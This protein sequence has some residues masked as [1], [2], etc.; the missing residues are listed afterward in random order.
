MHLIFNMFSF[1]FFGLA[2]ER[3]FEGFFA[4]SGK[5]IYLF[6]YVSALLMSLLPTYLKHRTNH[7]YRSLGASGAVSTV[8]F[9]GVM[10]DPIN[11]IYVFFIPMPGFVFGILYLVLTAYM[12]KKGGDSIN[13]SAHLWGALYGLVFIIAAGYIAGYDLITSFTTSVQQYLGF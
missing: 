11:K 13:H 12:D 7:N 5:W 1:F 10:L 2:V 6:M 8:I 9:A 4:G 3:A